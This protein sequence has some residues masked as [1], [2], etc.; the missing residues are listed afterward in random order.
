M[1][2]LYV[3]LLISSFLASGVGK[4]QYTSVE[5]GGYFTDGGSWTGSA[6]DK[7]VDADFFI[8]GN[9]DFDDDISIKGGD[10]NS[11]VNDGGHL[12]IQNSKTLILDTKDFYVKSGGILEVASDIADALDNVIISSVMSFYPLLSGDVTIASL[13]VESGA[14]LTIAAGSSVIIISDVTI[15][16]D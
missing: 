15:D 3:F 11:A 6:P 2:K 7:D 8:N 13:T 12:E 14:E 5:S 16:G 1:K 4:A 10:R 9:L